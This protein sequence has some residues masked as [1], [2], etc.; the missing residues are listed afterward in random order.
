MRN[1]RAVIDHYF[2]KNPPK[3]AVEVYTKKA[4]DNLLKEIQD[5]HMYS[6]CCVNRALEFKEISEGVKQL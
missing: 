3:N 6:A 5:S 4:M 2:N 1:A